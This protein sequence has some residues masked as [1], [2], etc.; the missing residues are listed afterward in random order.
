MCSIVIFIHV[1]TG[2]KKKKKKKQSHMVR[3]ECYYKLNSS[4][5]KD[6]QLIVRKAQNKNK[7]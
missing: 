1:S 5:I 7:K 3:C 4:R 6:Y 2:K